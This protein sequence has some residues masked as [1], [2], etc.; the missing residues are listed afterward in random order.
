MINL[1]DGI[2]KS[3]EKTIVLKYQKIVAKILKESQID[4]EYLELY[5]KIYGKNK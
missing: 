2:E 3:Y 1:S 5:E 4:R